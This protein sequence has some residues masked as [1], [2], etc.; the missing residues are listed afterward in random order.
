LT[1]DLGN[2]LESALGGKYVIERE[3]GGGGM[4]RVFLAEDVN[5]ARKVVIKVLPPE[6]A[7]DISGERFA[8]EIK[9]S[10][11][12][13]HPQIVSL[14]SAGDA[15]GLPYYVMP[16]V[17]GEGLR[18]RISREGKF[19]IRDVI[20]I[21]RDVAKALA[22]AHSKNVVHRDI[23]PENVLLT[24]DSAVVADFGIS[25]AIGAART[26]E[27]SAPASTLTQVG[28]SVGTPAYMAPEQ[29]A[30]DPDTDHRADIYSFGCLAY[31][32]LTG[33]A[34]FVRDTV[35]RLVAAHI[36]ERAKPVS[37]LRP[38]CPRAL[39][40]LVMRCLEK[41]PGNRPQSAGE[42]IRALDEINLTPSGA[43]PSFV[44]GRKLPLVAGIAAV[45]LLAGFF[46]VRMRDR[47]R[48]SP[49]IAVLPFKNIGG[50]SSA[51]YFGQ[52]IAEELALSLQKLP[53]VQVTSQTSAAAVQNKGMTIQDIGKALGVGTVLEGSVQRQGDHLHL[54]A[55]LS[56]TSDG[57]VIWTQPFDRNAKDLFEIQNDLV[58]AIVQALELRLTDA[59]R[60]NNVRGTAD[61]VAYD[62]YLQGRYAITQGYRS[63]SAM[64]SASTLFEKAISKDST[65]ARAYSGYSDAVSLLP[66]FNG[67]TF[68]SVSRLMIP[69]ARKAIALDPSLGEAHASL[70]R[71]F[72]YN[73]FRD[74]AEA[75]YR[76]A[77]KLDPE[78]AAAE[79]WFSS[80]LCSEGRI[81]ECLTHSE[82]AA[83][84]DPMNAAFVYYYACS[85]MLVGHSAEADSTF[86]RA[87]ALDS[88]ILRSSTAREFLL[89]RGKYED[90]VRV[91]EKYKTPWGEVVYAL[92]KLGRRSE[93][94]SVL[95]EVRAHEQKSLTDQVV[96]SIGVGDTLAALNAIEQESKA[97]H[98]RPP[99]RTLSDPI[100][101]PIRS[102]PRFAAYIRS[103][104]L[105]PAILATGKGGR[106]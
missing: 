2:R 103:L 22:F 6:L 20:A 63:A 48:P 4:S 86:Q 66:Y 88:G 52:G 60:A 93:A 67:A 99:G 59:A 106:P 46:A 62:Y 14:L 82:R 40:A 24:G 34:P 70:A 100:Y 39:A 18:E 26:H 64:S 57:R 69:A 78:Y 10:A 47:S 58:N 83:E 80:V 71:A 90:V 105:N 49:A 75:E 1:T 77:L 79:Q 36:S 104:G 19:P 89:D 81:N 76:T 97:P 30:G 84:L 94:D 102:S 28:T 5:L 32:M 25:K 74:S 17:E 61:P 98:P 91:G 73:G 27:G 9:V 8:R 44:V 56:N 50:D 41:D 38:D 87:L 55:S 21:L 13:Q 31:E 33:V 72:T 15:D 95:K 68:D 101:D 51:A 3:L 54:T 7:A 37:E 16:Y 29:A 53:G 92:A 85:Q 11:Q 43:F 65:F 35:H 45:I 12:L 42:L 23:K 96:A